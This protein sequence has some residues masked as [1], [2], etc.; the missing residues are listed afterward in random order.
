[1]HEIGRFKLSAIRERIG[2]EVHDAHHLGL[3][4]INAQTAK[5]ANK[6]WAFADER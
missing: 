3:R 4:Q 1:M 5:S 2:R 6:L